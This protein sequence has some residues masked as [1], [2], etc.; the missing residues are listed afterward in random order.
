LFRRDFLSHLVAL[1][2]VKL[3]AVHCPNLKVL[4][5]FRVTQSE[6]ELLKSIVTKKEEPFQMYQL[7]KYQYEILGEVEAFEERRCVSY[8]SA[9]VAWSFDARNFPDKLTVNANSN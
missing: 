9:L 3:A 8:S 1:S 7:T 4:I 2:L 5:T 6:K